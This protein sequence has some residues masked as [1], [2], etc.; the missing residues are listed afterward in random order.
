M[1]PP[2]RALDRI[3]IDQAFDDFAEAVRRAHP[4]AMDAT[5]LHQIIDGSHRLSA[6]QIAHMLDMP[7]GGRLVRRWRA[8]TKTIPPAAAHRLR[9]LLHLQRLMPPLVS[10]TKIATGGNNHAA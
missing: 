1:T 2:C 6:G 7:G 3:E 5:A 4:Q 8:G 9:M 10:E